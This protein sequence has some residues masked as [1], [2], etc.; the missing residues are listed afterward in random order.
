MNKTNCMKRILCVSAVAAAIGV[1]AQ[2]P[3]TPTYNIEVFWTDTPPAIDGAADDA[4]WKS[5]R[6]VT[7]FQLLGGRGRLASMQAEVKLCYDADNLYAF[8]LLHEKDMKKLKAGPPDDMRDMINF[9]AGP[10]CLELFLDPGR[11]KKSYFQFI[12]SPGGARYDVARGVGRAYNPTSPDWK[13]RTALHADSWTVEI[14]IPFRA[15]TIDGTS[16][17]TPEPG[18]VWGVNFCRDQGRLREWS[19]WSPTG[20]SFGNP[21]KFGEAIF[22][23]RKTGAS[24][25]SI[26]WDHENPM[27]YG[28]GTVALAAKP[29]GNALVLTYTLK[30]DGQAVDENTVPFEKNVA[31][32]YHIT[33][34]GRWAMDVTIADDGKTVFT[35]RSQV[36]LPS[37]AEML[38]EIKEKMDLARD[39]LTHFNHPAKADLERRL[40]RLNA[41]AAEPLTMLR[42]VDGLSR[43]EWKALADALPELRDFWGGL[44]F[45]LH[46]VGLYPKGVNDVAFVVGSAGPY[47]R[48]HRGDLFDGNLTDAITLSLA[49]GE[50]ESFQL[51]VIPFWQTLDGVTVSF[52]DLK[53]TRGTISKENCEANIVDYVHLGNYAKN[54]P[55]APAYEPDILWPYTPFQATASQI[56]PVFVN[57]HLPPHTPKGEYRGT[58]TVSANG[59]RVSREIVVN[60]FGFDIPFV[61]SLHIDPW[62]TPNIN[63][64]NF[65]GNA[66][67][68]LEVYEEHLKVLSK[69]RHACFPLDHYAMGSF[70]T[71]YREADGT[72]SFDF[73]KWRE[74]FRLGLKYGASGFGASFGCNGGA[75]SIFH[76]GSVVDR[77]TGDRIPLSQILKEWWDTKPGWSKHPFYEKFMKEYVALLRETG[78]LGIHDFEM[79]DEPK[80]IPDWEAMIN[81]HRYLRRITPEL[82]MKNFGFAPDYAPGGIDAYG[83]ADTWA[84]NLNHVTDDQLKQIY[85]RRDKWGE[86]F[87]FYTCGMGVDPDG[88][89]TPF[90][91]YDESYLGARMHGWIAWKL[92][93]DGFLIFAMTQTPRENSGKK[94]AAERFPT[95]PWES[96]FMKGNGTLVYPGPDWKLIP[97]MRLASARDGL[98]DY[99][100]FKLLYDRLRYLSP[101]KHRT[102]IAEI[103]KELTIEPAIYQDKFHW[104]KS[105]D[106]LNAKRKR[107]AELIR[108]VDELM[109]ISSQ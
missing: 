37:T 87:M 49:G 102:L 22:R 71:I 73:S 32:P 24:L 95:V 17:G 35:G 3:D 100:Y 65:Y 109:G 54:E 8:W 13:S 46:I 10:D 30:R 67:F 62:Y 21:A 15:L 29:A 34:S 51:L 23:G 57:V 97:S 18:A 90:I 64:R 56:Q 85:A 45:D 9:A 33:R 2:N 61:S 93:A 92:K 59:Q 38:L 103:E 80:S 96:G 1:A 68:T 104:T 82:K 107:L 58:V 89:T 69:Y 76:R 50:R 42:K 84:P 72:F 101:Q 63:W 60:S 105:T 44:R 98:E 48:V 91:L 55:D 79:H 83:W 26:K 28:P 16:C 94:T 106:L 66:A 88:N 31:I 36:M 52:S 74:V 4:C 53:G 11:S 41:A 108:K 47:E 78:M 14:A 7:G 40:S 43:E 19:Y 81:N 20:S 99:E 27:Y 12:V 5:A 75:Y 70:L 25:P 86:K 39:K 77:E 6:S